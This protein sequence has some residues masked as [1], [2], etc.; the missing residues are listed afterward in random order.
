MRGKNFAKAILPIFFLTALAF[1]F[2]APVASGVTPVGEDAWS[3]ISEVTASAEGGDA[4][5][6]Y[7]LGV[8][9]MKGRGITRDYKKALK[10]FEKAAGQGHTGA[11]TRIGDIYA[12]GRG[13]KRDYREAARW[14]RSAAE[15]GN[16]K[17]QYSLGLMYING[18]GV[19]RDYV[20]SYMW[21]NLAGAGG[22]EPARKRLDK[23]E[24]RMPPGE[25]ELA[26][27]LS[28]EFREK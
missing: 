21:L 12:A 28:R 16:P 15:H 18:D 5:A 22:F 14:Y 3:S 25:V 4:G 19:P 13:V 7:R 1:F 17:A 11:Q 27:K 26:Q 10:W 8:I 2:D 6:Q 24:A 9:Y 20:I 23:L